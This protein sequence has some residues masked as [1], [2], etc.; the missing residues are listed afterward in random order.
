MVD[1]EMF[2]ESF[3]WQYR[4]VFRVMEGDAQMITSAHGISFEQYLL[5]KRIR[6]HANITLSE[7]A[8]ETH[9]TRSA[10][11][12]KLRTLLM[13]KFV[14]QNTKSDDRRVK[15][16]VLTRQGLSTEKSIRRDFLTRCHQWNSIPDR[17]S[18]TEINNFFARYEHQVT[19][20]K[21]LLTGTESCH[22]EP[23]VT[24]PVE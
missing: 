16:L 9:T 4:E 2:F 22:T 21:S 5:L 11:A 12:R 1:D 8:D 15:G 17:P 13:N 23:K 10:A 6:E 7:L 24:E 20:W 18:I 14:T 3:L 19:A